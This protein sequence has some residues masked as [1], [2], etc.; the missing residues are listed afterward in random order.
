MPYRRLPNTDQA[1]IR[2]MKAALKQG[3]LL[4]PSSLAFSQKLFLELQSFY[5]HFEQTINQYNHNRERQ[6]KIGQQLGEHY[7]SARLFVSHFLQVVNL[8]ILRGE[9]KPEVR[10]FYGINEE[11][12]AVPE[13]GTEQ[14][15]IFWGERL[16]K[17][18]ETRM[19]TGAT[20][21]YNPSLAM[22]RVKYEKFLE[23]YNMHKDLLT[24]SQ[25]FLEKVTDFRAHADQ[26]ILDIWNDVEKNFESLQGDEKREKSSIYGL[27]YVYRP[28][29]KL[30][31][32]LSD[33]ISS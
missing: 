15:L 23:S 3:A 11:E 26:I 1:R 32:S 7:R 24:T 33:S 31:I 4:S 29:E 21:I 22:V 8:C 19:S 25:K 17:G 18:E 2:A 27:V 10:A 14:Q 13:I 16:L 20:R 9:L 12:K 30:Q 6:A 28:S 5:P